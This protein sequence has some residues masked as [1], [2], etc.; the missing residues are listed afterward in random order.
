[1]GAEEALTA[2]QAVHCQ[3]W[4]GAYSQFAEDRRGTLEPGMLADIAVLS[5]DI[6][7]AEPEEILRATRCDITLRGGAPIFDRHGELG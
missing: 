7:T 2:E 3:T 6:F 1:M 5:R 4:C